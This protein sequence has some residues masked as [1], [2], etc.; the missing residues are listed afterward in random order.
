MKIQRISGIQKKYLINIVLLLALALLLS[1]VGV[2]VYVRKNISNVVL[3]KYEF[4]TEKMGIT[5]DGLYKKSE[6]VTAECITDKNVQRSLQAAELELGEK[7][8]LSKY[9]AYT[10]LDYVSEYCYIDNKE[11][12]YTKS[13]SNLSYKD[14][15]KSGIEKKLSSNYAKTQWFFQEDTLFQTG[16]SELF[17]GRNVRN[18]EDAHAP[19]MLFFKM[20]EKYLESIVEEQNGIED[21][22]VGV[23]D[24]NYNVTKAEKLI[25][26]CDISE[27]ISLASKEA[28]GTGNMKFMLNG[29]VTLGTEDGAN[30]EIHQLVGDDNIYIFGEKSEKIIKLYETGEYCAADIYDNDPMVE[31]L[32]DFIIS[33]DLMRIGDP[34]NLGRLYKEI[35]EKDWFMALL[36]V[37]DYIQTKEQMLKDY[38][39][40]NAWAKKMLVNIAKAGF[41]SS[42]RTIAEY[43]QDIWHL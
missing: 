37:K 17:I 32:V 1:S 13:Y 29:A 41:F 18:M 24:D 36:D 34:V 19:G 43:N 16:R 2:G 21:I 20:D 30:V 7:N 27:Q 35:V 4:M 10:D 38:E 22:V 42:D 39:D 3:D 33:K 31:E 14:F 15:K 6:E 5:L 23:V 11:N 40:K 25:P 8:A 26:S 12:V 28:S 9:F